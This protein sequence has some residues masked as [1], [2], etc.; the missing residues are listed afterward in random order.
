MTDP[1]TCTHSSAHVHGLLGAGPRPIPPEQA[2][3][4][5][6]PVE[7]GRLEAPLRAGEQISAALGACAE[8]GA[9]VVSVS[10]WNPADGRGEHARTY[11]TP[12]VAM[13]AIGGDYRV[14]VPAD[15]DARP[16]L[17]PLV[18]GTTPQDDLR[19]P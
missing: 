8:C 13:Y 4:D 5:L 17:R 10:T 12:W 6:A 9:L 15:P 18:A 11:Q 3:L 19:T 2:R 1:S 7:W 14:P 16:P